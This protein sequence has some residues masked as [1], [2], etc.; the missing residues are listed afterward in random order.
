MGT[1]LLS[2]GLLCLL[3]GLSLLLLH[4]WGTLLFMDSLTGGLVLNC[5]FTSP[6]F[7][8]WPP[9]YCGKSVLPVFGS[10]SEFVALD[11]A[12]ILVCV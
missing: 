8:M 9:L 2:A 5:V 7:S 12:V 6:T 4:A 1:C 10:F 11:V 3:Y